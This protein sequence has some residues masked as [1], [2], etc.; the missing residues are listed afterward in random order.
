MYL[1]ILKPG[2]RQ[3]KQIGKKVELLST[4]RMSQRNTTIVV[5]TSVNRGCF[6]QHTEIGCVGNDL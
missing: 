6:S 3:T 4:T 2:F 1:D 5:N